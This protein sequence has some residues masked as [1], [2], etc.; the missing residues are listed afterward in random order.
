MKIMFSYASI[1]MR[2]IISKS[3]GI[4][5]H[6]T[7]YNVAPLTKPK[8]ERFKRVA[9]CKMPIKK[10]FARPCLYEFCVCELHSNNK[11]IRSENAMLNSLRHISQNCSIV[12]K[13]SS[14]LLKNNCSCVILSALYW[15]T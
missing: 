8:T 3:F 13:Y 9:Y 4:N 11:N 5:R 2:L 6:A 12:R 1:I 14:N 10:E 7:S 15:Q